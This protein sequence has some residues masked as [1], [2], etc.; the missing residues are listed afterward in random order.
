MQNY[1]LYFPGGEIVGNTT[2]KEGKANK[3]LELLS[4]SHGVSMAMTA[5]SGPSAAP[6]PTGRAHH[7]DFTVTKYLDPTSPKLN[8]YCSSGQ[9]IE[10]GAVLEIYQAG[11][12]APVKYA[13]YK[14]EG[15]VITSVSVGGGGSDLPTETVTFSYNKISWEFAQQNNANGKGGASVTTS[16][17]LTKNTK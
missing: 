15:I 5:S 14:L 1:Y 2:T 16:W 6:R 10:K 11:G 4:Y 13:S 8:E 12:A 7:N 3:A 9:F 17:D